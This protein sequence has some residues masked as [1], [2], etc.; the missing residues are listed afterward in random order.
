M[1]D[2]APCARARRAGTLF[3]SDGLFGKSGVREV[4]VRTGKTLKWS[5]N[6]YKDFGEGLHPMGNKLVQLTWKNN[7]INEFKKD[8]LQLIRRIPVNIG[9]EGWGLTSDPLNQ[10]LYITDSTDVSGDPKW[11]SNELGP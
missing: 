9:R 2:G 4:E 6:E 5:P 11:G 3:E 7:A 8:S 1:A 10:L